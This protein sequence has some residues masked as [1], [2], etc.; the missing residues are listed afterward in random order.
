MPWEQWEDY[1]KW[2]FDFEYKKLGI[3]TPDIVIYL[4]VDPEI[5]QH[6][7]TNRYAGD[8]SKKDIHEKN[9]EYLNQSQKAANF[10]VQRLNWK[11]V[12]CCCN[13]KI[14]SIEEIHNEVKEIISSIIFSK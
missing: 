4:K 8:D 6:L 9:M 2:L 5:S 13:G 1:I 11:T 10:C 7:M 12:E 3:P 14:K